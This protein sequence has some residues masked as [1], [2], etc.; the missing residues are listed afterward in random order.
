[1]KILEQAA[2]LS[3][4]NIL[5]ATDLSP[6]SEMALH[7]ARAFARVHG[8]QVHTLHV[9]GPDNYQLLCPEAFAATFREMPIASSDDSDVLK[10]LLKGLPCEV[11]LHGS[12]VWDVTADVVAR[13]E[14][15]LLILGT[16]GR[17]GLPKLL[18]GSVAEEVFRDV[19]CPVLTVGVDVKEPPFAMGVDKVLLATDGNPHSNAPAYAAWLSETFGAKLTVLYVNGKSDVAGAEMTVD[20]LKATLAAIAPQII[21]LP[22]RPVFVLEQGEP[23]HKILRTAA[24]LGTD[25]VVLGA[26]HP[27]NLRAASHL[28]WATTTKVIAGAKC[29]VLTVRDQNIGVQDLR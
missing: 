17:T 29:P 12:R 25:V 19:T 26:H 16:H 23:A 7:Y 20:R 11:P 18:L 28:P 3:L 13:N 4:K 22:R 9:S 5:L 14:I 8:A 1:M 10:G 6:S 2:S 27:Q 21:E 24:N 15:D